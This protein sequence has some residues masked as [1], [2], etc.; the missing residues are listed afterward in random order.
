MQHVYLLGQDLLRWAKSGL[1]LGF[2]FGVMLAVILKPALD[3]V[4]FRMRYKYIVAVCEPYTVQQTVIGERCRPRFAWNQIDQR[5]TILPEYQV[6][7]W[8]LKQREY[9]ARQ[10][11]FPGSEW[12]FKERNDIQR[13]PGTD[14]FYDFIPPSVDSELPTPGYLEKRAL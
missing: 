12:L 7:F 9:E 3:K 2:V 8:E 5:F 1:S 13:M 4:D 14:R 6:A 10:Q 11:L